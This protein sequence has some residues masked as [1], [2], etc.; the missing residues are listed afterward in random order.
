MKRLIA[1]TVLHVH[2]F[3]LF[4]LNVA[5]IRE[6]TRTINIKE[7]VSTKIKE[8]RQLIFEEFNNQF[9]LYANFRISN[10]KH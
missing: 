1:F 5:K 2:V 7:K 3:N 4:A 10:D 8:E 6:S 9:F